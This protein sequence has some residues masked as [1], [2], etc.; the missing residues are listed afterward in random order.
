MSE[1]DLELESVVTLVVGT[2]GPPGQRQFF[3]QAHASDEV[4]TLACEKAHIQSL[5]LRMR[6]LLD[7]HQLE[8]SA[9]KPGSRDH[10]PFEPI[11]DTAQ[12]GVGYHEGKN[13]FV[14][15]AKEAA[16]EPEAA[17]AK[18][19]LGVPEARAFVRQAEEVLAAG[20]P[21]CPRCGLP[22]DPAGHPC[23]ASNGSRP[24]F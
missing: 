7:A 18:F 17:T 16:A 4:V 20:R 3:L 14:V 9:P 5:V 24:V 13:R 15:V 19:W 11:W 22:M 12:L 1:R 10:A 8:D 6:Q 21:N 23:P 2:V